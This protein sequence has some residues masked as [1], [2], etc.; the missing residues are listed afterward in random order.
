MKQEIII[1][2]SEQNIKHVMNI[3]TLIAN[4]TIITNTTATALPSLRH[5]WPVMGITT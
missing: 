4:I 2:D 5:S 3:I 1:D